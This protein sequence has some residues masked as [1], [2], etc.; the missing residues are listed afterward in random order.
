MFVGVLARIRRAWSPCIA[1]RS[2]ASKKAR[3]R[4]HGKSVFHGEV[5]PYLTVV[6]GLSSW[7]VGLTLSGSAAE[8]WVCLCD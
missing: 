2:E 7:W 6:E 1:A 4:I 5:V 3:D 8:R